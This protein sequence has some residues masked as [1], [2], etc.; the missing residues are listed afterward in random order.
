MV[1]VKDK[2]IKI[3]K[4][5]SEGS[6]FVKAEKIDHASLDGFVGGDTENVLSLHFIQ[7]IDYPK[8][9]AD[10]ESWRHSHCNQI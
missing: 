9:H 8:G 5:L 3:H 2:P 10:W 1:F 6:S 7:C 4:I